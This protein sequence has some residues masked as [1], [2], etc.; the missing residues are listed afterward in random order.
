MDEP[1]GLQLFLESP[2]AQGAAS[3]AVAGLGWGV[4]VLSRARRVKRALEG[5]EA[6]RAELA[7]LREEVE[8][9]DREEAGFLPPFLRVMFR[10]VGVGGKGLGGGV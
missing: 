3:V 1:S 5:E 10:T 2:K 7:A 4:G 8:E 6:A 9:R